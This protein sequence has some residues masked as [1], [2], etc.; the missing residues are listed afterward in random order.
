VSEP[1][2]LLQ[3]AASADLT[4]GR[5]VQA[6]QIATVMAARGHGVTLVTRPSHAVAQR[7]LPAGV[8]HVPLALR[9]RLDLISAVRLR[10]LVR[11]GGA[12][13]HTHGAGAH[14]VAFLARLMRGRSR[15]VVGHHRSFPVHRIAS[16]AYRA[17]VVAA[18]AATCAA[19]RQLLVQGARLPERH[20]AVAYDGV[21]LARFDP[22]R[23]RGGRIRRELGV[24][25]DAPLV[26]QAGVR[27]WKGGNGLL[28]AFLQVR[29]ELPS[30]HLLLVGC[31]SEGERAEVVDLAQE[32]RME[33]AV[34]VL[35]R[36]EDMP[37][38]LAACNVVTDSSWAGT[39]VS[40]AVRE[41]M[42][43]GRA[44]VATDRAGNPEL[45]EHGVSGLLVEP[46]NVPTLAAGVLRLLRDPELAAR[47]GEQGRRR[48]V[49]RFSV[50]RQA[51]MLERIY[52]DV[53][54]G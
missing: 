20:V 40:A 21:D 19:V 15:L 47:F 44:V 39:G 38:I 8:E 29:R 25:P 14:G 41:A 36:R 33:G 24:P 18:V 9:G 16:L 46:R 6:V 53:L 12:V 7:C 34:H 51:E 50:E 45:V 49:E 54:G 42:A 10:R 35:L 27:S 31:T 48:V 3:V 52:R 30:S 4:S 22:A 26:G 1:L 37:D 28:R 13:M 32:M 17:P 2:T 43:L 11:T 5:L 23:A